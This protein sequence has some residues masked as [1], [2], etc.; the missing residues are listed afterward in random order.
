MVTVV[1][2]SLC[3][4]RMNRDRITKSGKQGHQYNAGNEKEAKALDGSGSLKNHTVCI[5]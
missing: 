1:V 2:V 4:S 3:T 5:Q